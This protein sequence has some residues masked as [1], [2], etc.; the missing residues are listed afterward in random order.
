[1]SGANVVA[2]VSRTLATVL[3]A[4]TGVTVEVD[5]SPADAIPDSPALIHL[6]LYRV[7][8][9]PFVRNADFPRPTPGTLQG[10]P[11][12]LN[13][14]YLITPYG[15]GQLQIQ[16]MLGEVVRAFHEQPIIDPALFDV[17]LQGTTEDLRVVPHSLGLEQM[18]E[19]WR[20][21]HE[22]SY[23]LSLT[24][25]ASL[26]LIDS[27]VSRAVVPVEERILGLEAVR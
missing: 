24:Y 17:A 15:S 5:R 11:V 3:G 18:T 6:Y 20:S 25:E 12:G 9:S 22:R 7:I 4:A 10:P 19:L 8:Q 16:M 1:M 14:F 21:F 2:G 13:L 26:V 23:R 27:R